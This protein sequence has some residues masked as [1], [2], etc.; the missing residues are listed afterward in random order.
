[1]GASGRSEGQK[2]T[3]AGFVGSH[4]PQF[5]SEEDGAMGGL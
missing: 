4:M 2:V 5:S 1:M 3:E